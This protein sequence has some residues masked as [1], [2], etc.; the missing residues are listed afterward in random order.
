MSTTAS[1]RSQSMAGRGGT[2]R[3]A[4]RVAKR[5]KSSKYRSAVVTHLR[6]AYSVD[7]DDAFMFHALRGGHIDTAGLTFDHVR[8]DT[9]SLNALAVAGDA[10]VVA[11]SAG[12]YPDVAD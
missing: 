1:P 12:A 8:A 9:A 10:D 11:I 6:L 5:G 3:R 4:S 7:A 2:S